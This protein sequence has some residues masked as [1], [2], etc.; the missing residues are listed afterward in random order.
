MPTDEVTDAD[1]DASAELAHAL[2]MTADEFTSGGADIL[3]KAMRD[4]RVLGEQR[5]YDRAIAEV[6]AWLRCQDGYG[7]WY[8]VAEKI[9][10]GEHKP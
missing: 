10:A 1:K 5:G 9:E 7:E 4:H 8:E 2:G 6:V 3:V